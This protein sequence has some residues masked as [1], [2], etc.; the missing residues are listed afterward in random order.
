MLEQIL[1][2][3]AGFLLLVKGA[4]WFVDGSAALALK[5]KISEIVIGLTLVAFGTSCPEL[6]VNVFASY[7]ANT[8]IV[9]G[10]IIGSNIANVLL[11]LGVSGAIF[12][13]RTS[14]NTIWKEI[15]FSLL[16]ALVVLLLCNNFFMRTANPLMLSS[17]EGFI[18]LGFF[19]LFLIYIY[20]L[21]KIE[22]PAK[23]EI[24]KMSNS[25]ILGYIVLGLAGLVFGGKM[26]V[27]S[28]VKI[29]LHL[30]V[31]EKLVGLTI[32]A[33]GTSLPELVTSALAAYKGKSDIAMGNVVGSN[34]FNIFFILGISSIIRPLPFDIVLNVDLYVLLAASFL[35]FLF[36]FTGKR[37]SLDRWEAGLFLLGYIGYTVYLI[38][39]G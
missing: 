35:L 10:N 25:K 23:P 6:V 7:N 14:K 24:P 17:F 15:P 19:V 16:S 34:I 4:D 2:L 27:D 5:M 18:L 29:A 9:F 20:R 36:M 21:T 28:S 11:I 3:V 1:F 37:K 39:R 32:V 26:A 30:G 12:P 8:G 33:I 22:L 13:I 38:Q 31:T